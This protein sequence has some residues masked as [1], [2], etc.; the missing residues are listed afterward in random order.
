MTSLFRKFYE[1]LNL[2][3]LNDTPNPTI[4]DLIAKLISKPKP[5][6][7][8]KSIAKSIAKPIASPI[9]NPKHT[10]L[11]KDKTGK[12]KYDV[13]PIEVV[14]LNTEKIVPIPK[15]GK[16]VE[17]R[18]A[19]HF[20]EALATNKFPELNIF[21]VR[22]IMKT[23]N[24][25]SRFK[26]LTQF[27]QAWDIMYEESPLVNK[28]NHTYGWNELTIIINHIRK[29]IKKDGYKPKQHIREYMNEFENVKF[30]KKAKQN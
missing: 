11:I 19:Y 8:P 3:I 1:K 18:F 22:K 20:L 7:K 12:Y 25:H 10:F 28:K 14:D 21:R 17:E 13:K 2:R 4:S 15:D 30:I 9:I 23:G 16:S 26:V 27:N 6:A 24:K 29:R 5:V